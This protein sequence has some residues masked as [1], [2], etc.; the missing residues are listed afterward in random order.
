MHVFPRH[1]LFWTCLQSW[2]HT[3]PRNQINYMHFKVDVAFISSKAI[4]SVQGTTYGNC[5]CVHWGE[6]SMVVSHAYCNIQ[7]VCCICVEGAAHRYSCVHD[8]YPV[9]TRGKACCCTSD[10]STATVPCITSEQGSIPFQGS[11]TLYMAIVFAEDI[12]VPTF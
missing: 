1:A 12:P 7:C 5:A 11:S 4:T 6:G 2:C 8:Y 3:F 10:I 9:Q